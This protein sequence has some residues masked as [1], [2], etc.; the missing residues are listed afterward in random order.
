MIRFL[1]VQVGV[2]DKKLPLSGY[3]V[4]AF[5][6]FPIGVTFRP[7]S[8]F[9]GQG[10]KNGFRVLETHTANE[11]YI[12][13]HDLFFLDLNIQSSYLKVF[14]L[15]QQHIVPTLLSSP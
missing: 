8:H 3:P 12:F 1:A 2:V 9:P 5:T 10:I 7:V 14:L 4:I 6:G 15:F 13:T 11:V